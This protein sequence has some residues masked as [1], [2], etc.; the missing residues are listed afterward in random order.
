MRSVIIQIG[1][2]GGTYGYRNDFDLRRVG[3]ILVREGV[4]IARQT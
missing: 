2:D 4:I 3:I 1:E